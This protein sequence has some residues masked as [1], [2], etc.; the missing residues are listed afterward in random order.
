MGMLRERK[1]SDDE[2][3]ESVSSSLLCSTPHN[4]YQPKNFSIFHTKITS[5]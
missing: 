1:F 5:E 3:H 4:N 2:S